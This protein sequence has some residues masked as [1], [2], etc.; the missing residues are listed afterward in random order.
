[1]NHPFLSEAPN[2][3]WPELT[4]E[5]IFPDLSEALRRAEAQLAEL[6]A[7]SPEGLDYANSFGAYDELVRT[8][9]EPWGLVSHL[10]SVQNTPALREAYKKTQPLVTRFFSGL[11]L[12]PALWAQ[13]KSYG[14]S[15]AGAALDPV[16]RRHVEEVMAD[17]RE[18]GADLEEAKKAR[19]LEIDETLARLTT[20]FGDNYLDTLNA[21]EMLVTDPADLAG[22]PP[23]AIAAARES[24]KEK[25]QGSEDSPVWRFTLQAPS[26][27]PF[28]RYADR[29]ERRRRMVE[30]YY[31]LASEAPKDNEPILWEIIQ[32]RHEKAGILGKANF[33]DVVLERRMAKNGAAALAFEE[34]LHARIHERFQTE[35]AALEAFRAEA[36]GTP[37]ARMDSWD[38]AYWAEKMRQAQCAFDDEALRPY[39]SVERVIKGLFA[40]TEELFGVRVVERT[41]SDKPPVWHPEVQVFDV[42][43]S[44]TERCCGTFF[45]DWHPRETK[46]S[47]AWMIPMRTG[48]GAA[49]PHL[50]GMCGNMTKPIGDQPALLLHDE[51]E[52]V[53][54]EFGHLLHHLLSDVEVPA[55]GGTDVAWDFVEL[56]S[57]I[58]ENWCWERA[59]L[60]RFACHHET[61][62][63]IPAELFEGLLRTRTFRAATM[64]MRQLLFGRTDLILHLATRE[65]PVPDL[66]AWWRELNA[67]YLVPTANENRSNLRVFSHLFSEPVGYAA[68][69][70]SYMWADVLASDAFSR[71]AREGILN[72]GTGRA[73]REAILSKGNSAPP[74]ALF[75]AF[76]GR[77]PDPEALLASRGLS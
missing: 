69:Y 74:E 40:L 26:F 15:A 22:L 8:V 16:R 25:G 24:A 67:D 58:M 49:R 3:P 17:F 61:G 2:V 76:M 20:E 42:F 31:A 77:D 47:G 35:C 28:V 27:G 50:G 9:S 66:D 43:D 71:F 5:R 62:E 73:F 14:E 57:Q 48:D 1:M 12:N 29:G 44:A 7:R 54:H 11:P 37:P 41:G 36:E 59:S 46:R 56:P 68:G 38:L 10:E 34:D 64:M 18:S 72:A 60:D 23:S 21:F 4:P 51:V 33:A 6:L 70:Y 30:G 53:F 52:T 63:P 45:T 75:R 55:L 13:L 65:F 32:L 19:V 39:F